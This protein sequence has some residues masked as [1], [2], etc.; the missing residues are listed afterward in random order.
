VVRRVVLNAVHHWRRLATSDERRVM[1]CDQVPAEQVANT[2]R[3]I[4]DAES[5]RLRL[6]EA[7]CW[8]VCDYIL[9]LF[10]LIQPTVES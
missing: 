8:V 3:Y 10:K 9:T 4:S 5:V 2:I 1:S 7:S 6:R